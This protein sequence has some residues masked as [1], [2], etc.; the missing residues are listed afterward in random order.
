MTLTNRASASSEDMVIQVS[1]LTKQFGDFTAVSDLSMSIP[2][3]VV[4]GFLGPNGSGKTTAIRTMCG[5]LEATRGDISILNMS[6][7][8]QA[9]QIRTQI[10]YMTQKFSMYE[11]LTL[12]ENLRFLG[13]IHGMSAE[14]RE[15]RIDAL[16]AEFHLE[17]FRHAIVGPMSGGQKRRIALA[18][19]LLTEPQLLIL[20]EPTSEVDPNT[21]IEIFDKLFELASQGR[22]VLVST[23]LMDEAERCHHLS[24][25]NNGVKVADGLTEDLKQD[26]QAQIVSV[27]GDNV[28]QL[29][30]GLQALDEVLQ[31][32]QIGLVLRVM[33]SH[34]VKNAETYLRPVVSDDYVIASEPTKIEDVFVYA[35]KVKAA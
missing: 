17:T 8:Q 29:A 9:E 20:D 3:G 6:M 11:D 13:Q 4:Y 10:G 16:L 14:Q 15:A 7:P 1:N 28:H 23:H 25:M 12:Y 27:S 5:L 21:R 24:I 30:A 18:A 2:K 33:L 19:A 22:T 35:T 26:L 31:V 32:T 34:Q